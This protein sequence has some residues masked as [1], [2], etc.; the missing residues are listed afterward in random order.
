MELDM[1]KEQYVIDTIAKIIGGP[2]AVISAQLIVQRLQDEGLLNLGYGNADIDRV[3]KT[4]ADT[5]G[6][7]KVS[8][9][10]R[11]AANR[12]VTKY[13]A[14]AVSGII[15]L[16]GSKNQEKYCPV[17]NSVADLENKWVSVMS[18]LRKNEGQDDTIVVG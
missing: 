9:A 5:F 3:V 12:L 10:D 6:T 2:N 8:K 17:V 16:L 13:S 1:N 15:S 18:F 4:F 14:Q 7:T 11:Y